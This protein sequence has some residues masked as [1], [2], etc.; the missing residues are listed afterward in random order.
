MSGDLKTHSFRGD[1]D[2]IFKILNSAY[3]LDSTGDSSSVFSGKVEACSSTA[4]YEQLGSDCVEKVIRG[5]RSERLVFTP[6]ETSSMAGAG[7]GEKFPFKESVAMEMDS[8]DPI[9]DFKRSMEEMV[10][11]HDGLK[12]WEFLE[13]LLICY[14]RINGKSTH[15][16]IVGA[17]VDLLPRVQ[18]ALTFICKKNLMKMR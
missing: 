1:G 15:G 14:L 8:T 17:F 2:G 7:A 3:N 9:T 16:Y 5:L 13:G 18:L 11:A 4:S 6:E 10:E 12:D